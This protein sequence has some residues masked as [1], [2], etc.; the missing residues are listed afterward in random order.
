M[1]I[2]AECASIAVNAETLAMLWSRRERDGESWSDIIQR[3]AGRSSPEM[4]SVGAKDEAGPSNSGTQTREKPLC[5]TGFG[6]VKY[7]VLGEARQAPTDID[8]FLDIVRTLSRC[9]PGL[10]K[11]A[12][13]LVGGRTRNHIARTRDAVYPLRPDLARD[14]KLIDGWY[15]GIN[16][17]AYDKRHILRGICRAVGLTFGIDVR[18]P[19]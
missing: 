6:R 5:V 13:P 10:L 16:I 7:E 15:V 17:S 14:A 18:V 2:N 1:S 3:M 12:A 9:E 19:F 11:R 4:P 8:A